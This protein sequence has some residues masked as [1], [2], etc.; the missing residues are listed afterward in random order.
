MSFMFIGTLRAFNL[1]K[2]SVQKL[3]CLFCLEEKALG[4][5]LDTLLYPLIYCLPTFH[6]LTHSDTEGST[7]KGGG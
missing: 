7:E 2:V 6:L 4:S 1:D 5:F 3:H